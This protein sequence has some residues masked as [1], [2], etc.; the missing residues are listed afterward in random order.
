MATL[1]QYYE[2][3]FSDAAR[4]HVILRISKI[5]LEAA[6]LYD[7]TGFFSY[8]VCYISGNDKDFDFFI[9]LIDAIEFGKTE[10]V[11]AGKI[12]LPSAKTFHGELR[13]NNTKDNIEISARFFGDPTWVDQRQLFF[14]VHP[15]YNE[16]G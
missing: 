12:S 4:I 16:Y 11:F 2:T 3:D 5:D 14:P 7:F 15:Y 6:V 1:L 13:Y 9:Q 8:F 10:M